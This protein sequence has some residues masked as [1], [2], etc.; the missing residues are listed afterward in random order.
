MYIYIYP[1]RYPQ[2][3]LTYACNITGWTTCI[4]SQSLS[5]C[6]TPYVQESPC[7]STSTLTSN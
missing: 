1:S 7:K 2:I 6:T 3:L 4:I 5:Y